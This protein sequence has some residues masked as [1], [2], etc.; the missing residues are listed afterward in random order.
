MFDLFADIFAFRDHPRLRLDP[1]LKIL[2]TL[3]VII[4]LLLSTRMILPL[5]FLV[6]SLLGMAALRLPARIIFLRLTVPMGLVSILVLIQAATSG[7]TELFTVSLWGRTCPFWKEGLLHGLLLGSRVA[8]AVSVLLLFSSIT[9]AHTIFSALRWFRVPPGWVEIALL[10][11]RYTFA[12]LDRAAEVAAAQ[13]VRLGYSGVGQS[14][15]SVGRLAGIV[16][17]HSFDQ[18]ARTYEAMTLRGYR[19]FI[20]FAPLPAIPKRESAYTL[21]AI[22]VVG[23]ITFLLE[24]RIFG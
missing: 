14:L 17:I 12:L 5:A 11:Y 2:I 22:G 24:R 1:R 21:L 6:L 15:S 19:G 13:K 8:G 7:R 4:C 18:A 3:A 10:M 16:L 9:P 20:P 23:A